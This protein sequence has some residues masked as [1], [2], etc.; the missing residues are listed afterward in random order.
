MKIHRFILD[1]DLHGRQATITD[2]ELVSQMERV[3]RL[4]KGDA[5]MLCNGEGEEAL[6]EI[7]NIEKNSIH[8]T[9]AEVSTVQ[10]EASRSVTLF[11]S[12]L[13]K[14]NF[15]WVAQKAVEVG[16]NVIV[17]IVCE[18][19]VKLNVHHSR[20]QRIIKEAAEQSGRGIV[21]IIQEPQLFLDS[22]TSAKTNEAVFLFDASGTQLESTAFSS[23]KSVSIFIGPEGGWT[24]TELQAAKDKN[25]HILT[26]GSRVMRAETAAVVATY[27]AAI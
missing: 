25:C 15:E 14:E 27:L 21:P 1:I 10:T 7:I 18:R 9:L 6:G 20:L 12:V 5:I 8:V 13:K 11:C 2:K 3:L 4:K 26:L 16:V 19:T 23:H 22:L 17:P 24:E